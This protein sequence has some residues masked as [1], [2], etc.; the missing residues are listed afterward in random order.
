MKPS[1][2]SN[3]NLMSVRIKASTKTRS[4]QKVNSQLLEVFEDTHHFGKEHSFINLR[5]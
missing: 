3:R 5:T 4:V 1:N 2:R